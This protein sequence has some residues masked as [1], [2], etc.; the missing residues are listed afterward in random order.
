MAIKIDLEKAYDR[1]NWKFLIQCLREISLPENFIQ[2]IEH[3][4]G[5]ASLQLLWNGGK[6]DVFHASR[7]VRQ[8]D[9]MAPYLFVICIITNFKLLEY[10][11]TYKKKNNLN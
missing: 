11:K 5:S 10:L 9:P 7:G 4:I 3:C 2:I 1:V 8:G 6:A